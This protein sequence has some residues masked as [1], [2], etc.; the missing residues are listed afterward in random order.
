MGRISKAVAVIIL[1]HVAGCASDNPVE[2]P[3]EFKVALAETKDG[4]LSDKHCGVLGPRPGAGVGDLLQDF[5]DATAIGSCYK[6][7]FL[8]LSDHIKP[9]VLKARQPP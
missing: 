1:A 5:N 2:K 4:M 7:L 8:K 6:D 9:L 3:N